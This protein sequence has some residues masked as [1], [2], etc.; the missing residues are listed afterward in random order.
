MADK[1]K[2]KTKKKVS[3]KKKSSKKSPQ[4]KDKTK[5]SPEYSREV[6]FQ[7]NNLKGLNEHVQANI[8][9][10][11]Q[12]E[13]NQIIDSINF[14]EWLSKQKD[15]SLETF[16]FDFNDPLY[17]VYPSQFCVTSIIGSIS[18]G[19]RFN[20]GANQVLS[21]IFP[22][23]MFGAVYYA[24]TMKCAI[25]EYCQ[26]TP[27]TL[28]DI[29]YT[30]QPTKNF[31]L[32]DLDKVV[33]NLNHSSISLQVNK[34]PVGGGW[35]NCKVPMPSQILASW[36]RDIGGDGILFTSTK[37]SNSKNIALFAK[38]D[39]ESGSLVSVISQKNI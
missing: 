33:S 18:Y 34:L 22:F 7:V 19:A 6:I 15:L 32:W 27:L 24:T 5:V 23:K 29:K 16:K 21:D 17:R 26:G 14:Y 30:L 4:K 36:L 39:I 2:K 1:V 3:A 28:N 11:Q 10:K 9:K 31:Q 37:D 25:D 8:L 12:E 35:S 13:K 20:I 38:D